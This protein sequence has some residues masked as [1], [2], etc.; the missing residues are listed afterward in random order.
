VTT[1]DWVEWLA[2]PYRAA[3][4]LALLFDYD[5]TLTP[6]AAHPALA[7]LA[8]DVRAA[9][10]ALA[11]LPRVTV[12]V[13]SGRALGSLRGLVGLPELGY[14]GSGGMH[15]DHGGEEV[16]DPAA[17]AFDGIADALVTTLAVPARW[18][19]G[20]WVERKP[21]CLSVHFRNLSPLKAACF[22]E[23]VR[24]ALAGLGPDCPPLRVR[25][26]SRALEV[27]PA[28]AWTR[29]DAVARLAPPGAL[30]LYAGDAV[31]DEEAVAAAN[32]RG[33]VTVGVGPGAPGAAAVR[34]ADQAEFEAGLL[35]LVEALEPAVLPRRR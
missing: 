33:G 23:E 13:V 5:G 32:A 30:V 2:A 27:S 26:V 18:F 9:L 11:A 1:L 21:G 4:P 3:R 7:E 25:E 16:V 12:G 20:A 15:L 28:G 24:D 17:A 29:G 34:L 10:A 6:P 22:V 19:P 31:H 8:A 35:R 14:A